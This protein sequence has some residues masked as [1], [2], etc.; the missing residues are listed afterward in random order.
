[1]AL[2]TGDIAFISFNGDE[3][4]WSIVTF[5]DI[6]PSTIIYF[7]DNSYNG[8]SFGTGESSFEWNTGANTITAGTV[9]RFSKI[10]AATRAASVGTFSVATG[11]NIGLSVSSE[12]IYAY[13]GTSATTPNVFLTAVST[14]GVAALTSAGLTN[15]VD[16]IVLTNST[17]YGIYNGLRTGESSF[18]NYKTLVNNSSNWTV[19]TTNDYSTTVPDTTSFTI[20]TAIP[21][22]NLVNSGDST[23]V[24]EGG[25]TDSYTVVLNS[26]PSQD[27]T[28]NINPDSQTITSVTTLTFTPSNWNIAQTVTVTAV[29]DTTVEGGHFSTIAHQINGTNVGTVRV[30]ISDNDFG[31]L[32]KIGSFTGQGAEITDYDPITKRLFVVD[33]SA[34]IRILNFS[35]PTNPTEVN[36]IDLTA[37]GSQANSVA[38]KNG[39]IAIALEATIT[40]DPGKVVF[41]DTAGNFLKEVTVGALPDMVTF[42]PD[43]T[44]VLTANEGEPDD[45]VDPEGSISIIDISQT[46]ANATVTTATFTS[47]NGQE[48]TLRS[49]GVRIFP[50]KTVAQD[51]EP[52]Y[53]TFSQDG[54]KA[55][56]T[57]QENN[58]IAIVDI[59]TATGE[60]IFGLGA[61]N[62][63][64]PGNELDA[65][66]SDGGINILNWPVFGLFMPDAIASFAAN[67]RTYYIT[68][69]EGDARDEDA[70]VKDL[71]LDPTIFPNGTLLKQDANLGRLTVSTIDGDTDG[72]GDYDQLFAYGTRSFSIWDDQG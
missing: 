60:N 54:T 43:G 6:V 59:A 41:F 50:G 67:G 8:T 20:A 37:Y 63:N 10:D 12:T 52:E 53:I 66:D 35:D 29:D 23:N 47:F 14:E 36:A 72:D 19:D 16:S 39:L 15:G 61:I 49:Q 55:W 45:G 40:T 46:V 70:R 3:D 58:A 24:T 38:V 56:V 33:G 5:V 44:K 2:A 9:I 42:S 21:I 22:V 64:Q 65:S 68:A 71:N 34:F 4:G 28:I 48:A 30:G 7:S 69:N 62:H 27:I 17:D 32:R 51:V 11:T 57:L 18:A 1:M 31:L 26:Q 13:L 25:A